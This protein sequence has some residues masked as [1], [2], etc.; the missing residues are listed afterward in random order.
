MAQIP[1]P[2]A[3]QSVNTDN[4]TMAGKSAGFLLIGMSLFFVMVAYAQRGANTVV[5]L[6]DQLIGT[7]TG[8]GNEVDIV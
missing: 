2:F 1:I 7:G 3:D 8:S 5:D 4:P 6:I